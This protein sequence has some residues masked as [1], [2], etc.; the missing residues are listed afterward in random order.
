MKL[1]IHVIQ[2]FVPSCLNSDMNGMPKSAFFGNFK[3]GRLSSQTQKRSSR[4]FK[5]EDSRRT[6]RLMLECA[7]RLE[8]RGRD[9]EEAKEVIANALDTVFRKKGEGKSVVVRETGKTQYLLFIGTEKIDD[10]TNLCETY[11]D[12]L[13]KKN[14]DK[15][16]KNALIELFKV[17]KSIDIALYGRMLADVPD[18]NREASCQV[19]HG[20]TTHAV[21]TETDW[22]SAADDLKPPD[23]TGAAHLDATEFDSPCY[24]RYAVLD[25]DHLAKELDNNADIKNVAE[26]FI[27]AFVLS[28]PTGK[29]NAFA[30]HN[31]PSLVM[32]VAKNGVLANMGNSFQKPVRPKRGEGLVEMS[33]NSFFKYWD[34]LVAVYGS[35]M[36][37]KASPWFIAGIDVDVP[38]SLAGEKISNLDDLVMKVKESIQ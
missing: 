12:E 7:D 32:V 20:I 21:E 2:N 4:L 35:A 29:Q 26:A 24:Y 34:N 17:D 27:R 8:K 13:K 10:L 28:L 3:R 23:E 14:S 9:K 19:A 38:D 30:A 15:A 18:F 1:E 16:V 6:L 25:I 36:D 11:W 37:I 5:N 31:L 22:F 33:V